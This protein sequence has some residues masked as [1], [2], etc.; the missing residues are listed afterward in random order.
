M[1]HENNGLISQASG[2]VFQRSSILRKVMPLIRCKRTE[3][4]NH[5]HG[6]GT[7]ASPPRECDKWNIERHQLLFAFDDMDETDGHR[8]DEGRSNPFLLDETAELE[9]ADGRVSKDR[10]S[11]VQ[12]RFCLLDGKKRPR[13]SLLPGFFEDLLI[14][15][16]TDDI[17][18]LIALVNSL[19]SLQRES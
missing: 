14:V 11:P 15:H 13:K 19:E 8:N 4:V 18:G 10:Q 17:R 6:K 2:L 5:A 12:D 9:K 1:T 7:S 16:M 3:G